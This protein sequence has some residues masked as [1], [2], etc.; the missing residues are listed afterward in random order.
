METIDDALRAHQQWINR[1]E[2]R[3]A[4]GRPISFDPARVRPANC[5]QLG[6]WFALPATRELLGEEAHQRAVS[7]HDTFHELAYHAAL[8]S[9][10]GISGK[11]MTELLGGL[12]QLS[13]QLSNMLEVHR[14]WSLA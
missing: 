9:S 6:H 8:M 5:C 14:R 3:L 1:F 2:A 7:M 13:R 12:K 11:E 4:T 10:M